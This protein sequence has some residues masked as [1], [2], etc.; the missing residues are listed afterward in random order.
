MKFIKLFST[1]ITIALAVA[2]I[3]APAM[4]RSH[5]SATS[6]VPATS[7]ADQAQTVR[8]LILAHEITDEAFIKSTQDRVIQRDLSINY[9]Q[10]NESITKYGLGK[11]GQ[12][13]KHSVMALTTVPTSTAATAPSPFNTLRRWAT[14]TPG[15]MARANGVD[16]LRLKLVDIPAP[17]A[18]AGVRPSSSAQSRATEK[19]KSVRCKVWTPEKMQYGKQFS[20]SNKQKD[21]AALFFA[22]G[23]ESSPLQKYGFDQGESIKYG[24]ADPRLKNIVCDYLDADFHCCDTF[25]VERGG[26]KGWVR[27]LSSHASGLIVSGSSNDGIIRLLCIDRS[28]KLPSLECCDAF[29]AT[30]GALD[31]VNALCFHPSGLIIA[32]LSDGAIKLL[33]IDRSTKTP[34]LKLCDTFDATIAEHRP[35]AVD[36]LCVHPSGLIV[37]GSHVGLICIF[38]IDRSNELPSLKFC[39]SLYEKS[40]GY[41]E[42]NVLCVPSS[43]LIIAGLSDSVIKLLRIDKSTQTPSLKLCDTFDATS[44]VYGDTVN[45]LCFHPSGLIVAG[46]SDGPSQ[47]LRIDKSTEL[48]S[49]KLRNAFDD[50][51]GGHSGRVSALYSSPSG[52]IVSGS[53]EGTISILNID[54]SSEPPSLTIYDAFDNKKGGH[55][56]IVCALCSHPS[57]LILSG[58]WDS[59][60]KVWASTAYL[61]RNCRR[62]R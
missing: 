10:L 3:P 4:D 45:A 16:E 20:F 26:H 25:G 56:S 52:L 6:A 36:A 54:R 21:F 12:D 43:N 2:T 13:T 60:I 42:T 55:T 19:D 30:R 59:T 27:A 53:R 50:K 32:G 49:P 61:L 38:D 15:N 40:N 41:G 35:A 46:L 37:A 14:T 8:A 9:P 47:L 31:T 7:F 28:N 39:D 62:H 24:D 23:K 17:A 48:S 34:S 51:K 58:S 33:R 44:G 57:G 22:L 5:G 18:G 1:T 29:K 11:A